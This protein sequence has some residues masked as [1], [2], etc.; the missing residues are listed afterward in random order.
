MK[1]QSKL[2][3]GRFG[4]RDQSG[5]PGQ[6][7]PAMAGAGASQD[8]AK[9]GGNTGSAMSMGANLRSLG[10][11]LQQAA[12]QS[13]FDYSKNRVLVTK[14][15]AALLVM[16]ALA[17][18]GLTLIPLSAEVGS[19]AKAFLSL[20]SLG[21]A[22]EIAAAALVSAVLVNLFPALKITPQGLGVAEVT[23][24]RTV[25][26]NQVGVIRVMELGGRVANGKY[27]VMIPFKGKTKPGT[28]APMLKWIPALMGASREG[29]QGVML[30]SDIK[31]FERLLQ[32]IVSY[33]VQVQGG[34]GTNVV[35]ELFVDEQVT[36]YTAQLLLDPAAALE[37]L[38]RYTVATENPD[39]YGVN[40]VDTDP[41]VN[42]TRMLLR[43][44]PIALLPPL[45]L[46]TEV[47][48]G[49]SDKPFLG[50]HSMFAVALLALG[51]VE[52]PFVAYLIQAVGELMVGGG[53]FKRSVWAYAELQVP[54]AMAVI[55]GLAALGI[56]MP[57]GFAL[58]LWLA[59]V[60]VTTL[61]TT[62]FVRKLYYMPLSHTIL[63]TI[64]VF[65]YQMLVLALYF[66]VR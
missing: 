20:T 14:T 38:S 5:G 41:P 6:A 10:S 64:G 30:T 33:M 57:S 19:W 8:E 28:P 44:L 7:A 42:W 54:R 17:H 24:W 15:V 66:W 60:A 58:A 40:E 39:P 47:L 36:M 32:L 27:L 34:T 55:L 65:I 62:R 22:L 11:E 52:L 13:T 1:L 4:K 53:K 51:L 31:Y 25:P 2:L 23:G 50:I 3:G 46:M 18:A 49:T 45:V 35:V 61:L 43:Q 9:A 26:W 12:V 37:R 21:L 29:E 59:G 48:V 56:G 16:L 63:A